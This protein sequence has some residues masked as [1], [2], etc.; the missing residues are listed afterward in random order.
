MI[1]YT[2]LAI[3]TSCI[4]SA[5]FQ[6]DA[7]DILNGIIER[8]TGF[9]YSS[10]LEIVEENRGIKMEAIKAKIHVNIIESD[11][12]EMLSTVELIL[13]EKLTGTR[14]LEYKYNE[15]KRKRLLKLP[16]DIIEDISNDSFYSNLSL[17]FESIE[18]N[19]NNCTNSI[20]SNN[21]KERFLIVESVCSD[22]TVK[23]RLIKF[24]Y[25]KNLM[26]N[27]KEYS[28]TGKLIKKISF[29]NYTVE[30]SW[31]FPLE[32]LIDEPRKRKTTSI[33]FKEFKFENKKM[34]ETF[35]E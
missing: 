5:D 31:A 10:V 13:P 14:I 8:S 9:S 12:L 20:T 35:N 25:S 6:Q 4:I 18:N 34:R 24:D 33:K 11:T 21:I 29:L 2:I 28:R 1:F 7:K 26:A 3:L 27:I 15:G 19:I 30:G 16:N 23:R 17:D 32:V 22:L